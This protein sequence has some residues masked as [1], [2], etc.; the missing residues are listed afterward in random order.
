MR[1]FYTITGLVLTA[2][3]LSGLAMFSGCSDAPTTTPKQTDPHAGHT[4]AKMPAGPEA[5]S[6]AERKL[7]LTPGGIYTQKDIEANGNVVPSV[8]YRDI[9]WPHD[10]ITKVGEPICPITDNKADPRCI[11]IVNGKSY[12]FCCTPC[13]SKFVRIAKDDERHHQIKAPEEYVSEEK[14]LKKKN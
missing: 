13:L 12:T 3:S 8:K 7:F 10:D 9:D 4:H 6:E 2:A 11:W 14:H 1:R 5:G